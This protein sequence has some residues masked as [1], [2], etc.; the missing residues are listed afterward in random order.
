MSDFFLKSTYLHL[1][2]HR[3]LITAQAKQP[4]HLHIVSFVP[5]NLVNDIIDGRQISLM[6]VVLTG[7][8]VNISKLKSYLHVNEIVREI[9]KEL[10]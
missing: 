3:K 4:N 5:L 7:P 8:L 2:P 9:E 6:D 1:H 10:E